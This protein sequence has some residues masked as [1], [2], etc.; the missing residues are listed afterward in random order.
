MQ[1]PAS[2]ERASVVVGTDES[3]ELATSASTPL[4]AYKQIDINGSII[5]IATYSG[6]ITPNAV[7]ISNPVPNLETRAK[8]FSSDLSLDLSRAE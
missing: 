8:W 3:G 1:K 4:H 7:P 5:A 2:N 6:T